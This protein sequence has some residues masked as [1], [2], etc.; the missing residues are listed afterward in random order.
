MTVER[1]MSRVGRLSLDRELEQ[2]RP[3]GGDQGAR[4]IDAVDRVL[5]H[6]QRR[7]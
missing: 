6:R 3:D 7:W 2:D 4:L 1:G 5:R